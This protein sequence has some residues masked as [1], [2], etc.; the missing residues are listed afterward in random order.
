MKEDSNEDH[1][2]DILDPN[3]GY[4]LLRGLCSSSQID[5]YREECRRFMKT[6]RRI[7][8]RINTDRI[9]DYVHPRTPLPNDS[10]EAPNNSSYT[11]QTYR[12]YQYFHNKH[13]RETEEFF[14]KI[15]AIR[16]KIEQG[17][18]HDS[19]YARERKALQEY[20][21][22]TKYIEDSQGLPK[23][24]DYEGNVP[25]PFLQCLI[26]LSEPNVDYEGGEFLL[27]TKRGNA[28]RIQSELG[29][30]K[31]DAL[32][33]DKTLYHMVEPTKRSG[34]GIGR[35]SV[36]VGARARKDGDYYDEIR[37][38]AFVMEHLIP[39]LRRLKNRFKAGASQ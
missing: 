34:S 26:L 24:R 19:L 16:N 7:Y 8:T 33:F 9:A 23:H 12:L 5:H 35:W 32:F 27:F 4:I 6:G 2:R 38:S 3:K 28:V 11:A 22:V 37:Y 18:M 29:V 39:P 31:G 21:I 17:W 20:V 13:S 14:S 25:Y 30:R 15:M 1:R 10:L 36:L